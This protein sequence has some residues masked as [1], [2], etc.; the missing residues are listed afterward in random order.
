M[1]FKGP[2]HC[3]ATACATGAHAVGDA[4]W[5]IARGDAD[6]MAVG[7]TESAISPMTIAGFGAARA[8]SRGFN[9][10]PRKASRP[11]DKDRDGFV[12]G[13]GAGALFWKN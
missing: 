13:E 1:D 11:W 9:D 3:V 12:M 5:M 7:S 4:M 6:V 2:N 8:L 10:E